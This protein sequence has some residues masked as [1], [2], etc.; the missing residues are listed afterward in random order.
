MDADWIILGYDDRRPLFGARC[1]GPV[2]LGRQEG[3]GEVLYA[4]T[5]ARNGE[6][7]LVIARP[8]ELNVSRRHALLTP[9]ADRRL[10][11]TNI[12][13]TAEV[14]LPDGQVLA[15]GG[16]SCELGLPVELQFGHRRISV[17]AA[18]P[19]AADESQPQALEAPTHLPRGTLLHPTP[20]GQRT[21]GLPGATLVELGPI[22]EKL[23]ATMTVL[24]SAASDSEF[25][26]KAAE[27]VVEVVELDSGRVLIL[28]GTT[29][30]T[31]AEFS[32]EDAPP[33]APGMPSQ[34]IL[35]RVLAERRTFWHTPVATGEEGTS[36]IGV[37]SVVVAPI[38]NRAGAVIGT[39]YGDRY[40]HPSQSPER[41]ITRLDAM[42]VDLLSGSIAAGLARQ[43]QELSALRMRTQFEQFFTPEL[44]RE[45][46]A[47]PELLEGQ[48]RDI[49]VLF[50][51]IRNFSRITRSVGPRRTLEWVGDVLSTL[52]DCVLEHG[53]VLVDYVG[54]ELLAMWGAPGFQPDHAERACRAALDMQSR[55]DPLNARWQAILG[56]TMGVGI[57]VNTGLARVGNTGSRSKFKYGPLGDTVNTGSRVQGANKLFKT[58]ILLTEAT[59]EALGPSFSVRRI[60]QVHLVGINEPVM[61]HE[62]AA[63]DEP[64]RDD[65]RTSY[66]AA[67]ARFEA[68]DFHDAVHRLGNILN[69]FPEDGPTLALLHRA[70]AKLVEPP[71]RFDP[72]FRLNVK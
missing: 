70:V 72:A 8:E 24:R 16:A 68:Q 67:L 31:V 22:L 52:S 54:D 3:P 46:A 53:G 28:E 37:N 15:P 25:L 49:S 66:E 50:C 29:W 63:A 42:L 30:R 57:G 10:K 60:G 32:S 45:L 17:Q 39:V 34:T 51:D 2:V 27:A 58:G 21:I 7:R 59:R 4:V 48:D 9:L 1:C 65:L 43:E 69:A 14:A 38:L 5:A 33:N 40:Y 35:N 6:Q 20:S 23:R 41:R 19:R 56:E 26:D 13:R 36:L 47:H 55:V 64:R 11:I 18:P 44:A 12:S 61:I 62:L 71:D